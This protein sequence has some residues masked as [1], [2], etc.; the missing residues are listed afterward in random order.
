[1]ANWY[2]KQGSNELGPGTEDQLRSAFAKGKV[3]N[4]TMVRQ[5]DSPEWVKFGLSGLG[6]QGEKIAEAKT[7][8]MREKHSESHSEPVQTTRVSSFAM[9]GISADMFREKPTYNSPNPVI[10][11]SFIERFVALVIDGV[12]I[13]ICNF[14]L[15]D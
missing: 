11:A 1:M 9:S 13:L 6:G 7:K 5:E 4:D 8:P 15:L 12:I 2:M 14:I 3:T 10:F